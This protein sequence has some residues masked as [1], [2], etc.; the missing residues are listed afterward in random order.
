MICKLTFRNTHDLR[1]CSQPCAINAS[2]KVL[3]SPLRFKSRSKI[4]AVEPGPFYLSPIYLPHSHYLSVP[5]SSV[6]I[7]HPALIPV[8]IALRGIQQAAGVLELYQ[9]RRSRAGEGYIGQVAATKKVEYEIGLESTSAATTSITWITRG[10][11]TYRF[12][13]L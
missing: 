8:R 6:L 9:K 10:T 3:L 11:S 5:L 1:S 2:T 4:V 13:H 7:A 12:I